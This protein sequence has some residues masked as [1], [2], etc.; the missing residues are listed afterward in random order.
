MANQEKPFN[1]DMDFDEALRRF[2]G[3]DPRELNE[4]KKIKKKER[5]KRT[6]K[7]NSV[8]PP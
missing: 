2:V 4:P 8:K 7:R 3:I 5:A 1:L 6:P